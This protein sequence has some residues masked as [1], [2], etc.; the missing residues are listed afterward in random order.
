[1][2]KRLRTDTLYPIELPVTYET[3]GAARVAG[4][5][6]T[7][8]ISRTVV[9][10]A[11]DRALMVGLKMQLVLAWPVPLAD[12]TRLNLCMFAT[13]K[14]STS[15]CKIEARVSKHQFRTRRR[16]SSA[17]VAVPRRLILGRPINI[18][19]AGSAALLP[20]SKVGHRHLPISTGNSRPR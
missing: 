1:M 12:G 20:C 7:L 8:A 17:E 11:G 16:A 2:P 6:R 14:R 4:H 13:V 5:G 10:F 3:L 18:T 9:R 15:S 19:R